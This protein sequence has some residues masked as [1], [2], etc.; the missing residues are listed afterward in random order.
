MFFHF[1]KNPSDQLRFVGRILL[2][3]ELNGYYEALVLWGPG[4][5]FEQFLSAI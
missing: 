1:L 4:P 2:C 5:L 3:F